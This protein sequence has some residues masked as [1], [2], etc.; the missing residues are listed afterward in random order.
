M[1]SESGWRFFR[2]RL[3]GEAD[4]L[5][6]KVLQLFEKPPAPRRQLLQQLHSYLTFLVGHQF[7]TRSA[8]SA[9]KAAGIRVVMLTGD[10]KTTARAVA[11]KLGTGKTCS[12]PSSITR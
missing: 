5:A 4:P 2:L 3:N 12:S 8:I 10:N 11:Q 1:K 6:S 7:R 9:L